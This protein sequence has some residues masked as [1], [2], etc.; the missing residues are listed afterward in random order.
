MIGRLDDG[1]RFLSKLE[2][3]NDILEAMTKSEFIG[4]HGK[5]R[6]ENGRN[7]FRF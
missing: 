3:D 5:V 1:T 4:R 7:L 2:K 6:V